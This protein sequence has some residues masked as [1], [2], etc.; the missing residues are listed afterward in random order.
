[1]TKLKVALIVKGSRSN[2]D[3]DGRNMG[4]WSY[5]VDEFEWDHFHFGNNFHADKK[6]F[7][8]YDLIFMEDGGN[9]GHW[10]GTG[11][12]VAFM[13]IDGTLSK[14]HYQIRR[15]QAR[16]SD[17]TF[18]DHNELHLFPRSHRLNYC[19]ND[20]VFKPR[21]KKLDVSFHCASGA[22][23]GFP[24]GR[25]RVDIRQA[26]NEIAIKNGWSYTSGVLG[27]EEYAA[28]MGES[29][30]IVNWP[31]T[32]SNR[33]HRIF[34]GMACKAAICTGVI[35]EV[36]GDK[37][38]PSL[39]YADYYHNEQI[40]WKDLSRRLETLFADDNWR[41]V[42]DTGYKLVMSEHTWKIRAPQL[43]QILR[44]ELGL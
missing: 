19:V 25:E 37:I 7:H 26:L 35:P 16:R 8:N 44:K 22:R 30:V 20:L 36:S 17:I 34:D 12:P 13:A 1:M 15:E 43:R 42:A 41:M 14:A 2:Y 32:P 23:K 38:T 27:L 11:P 18:V 3:R 33:P 39:H 10:A 21:E 40:G 4:Y 6:K 5:A 24:G 29:R 9:W 31:R 28:N